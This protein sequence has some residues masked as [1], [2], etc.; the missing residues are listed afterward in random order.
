MS[1]FDSFQGGIA[2]RD[3]DRSLIKPGKKAKNTEFATRMYRNLG[4]YEIALYTFRGFYKMPKGFL[5]EAERE[6]F[7]PRLD[8]YGLSLRGPGLGG[9]ANFEF[10]FYNSLEDRSGDNRL[11]E[12]SMIKYLVGYD[13]DL[14]NDLRIGLQYLIEHM[15]DYDNYREA[16]LSADFRRDKYRHLTTFRIT[17]LFKDQ[18]AETNLFTFFSPSDMDVYL[19]PN[20]SYKVTDD[21][22]LTTGANLVWGRD[23]HTEFGQMKHNKNIYLRVRYSF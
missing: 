11:I 12:N 14:G 20:I 9:I 19:R 15:L 16:L 1:F 21:W 8:A 18:T 5:S 2:G 13:K 7:Y 23:D 17:K 10:A 22:K 4:S 6:L 3:S